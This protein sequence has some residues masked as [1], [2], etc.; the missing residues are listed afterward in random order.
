MKQKI[1]LSALICMTFV[2]SSEAAIYS[3]TSTVKITS[4]CKMHIT[5]FYDDNDTPE[6]NSDD[7]YLG[8]HVV[9]DGDGCNSGRQQIQVPEDFSDCIIYYHEDKETHLSDIYV[10]D[11]VKWISLEE[12]VGKLE[13]KEK[14]KE[15]ILSKTKFIPADNEPG[16]QR[17]IRLKPVDNHQ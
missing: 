13:L 4:D 10:P 6:D 17:T 8:Y 5:R 3:K 9:L 14:Q 16:Q 15:E 7:R 12:F 11:N 2:L 1:I